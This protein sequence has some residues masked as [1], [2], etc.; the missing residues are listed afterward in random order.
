MTTKA[1]ESGDRASG[2]NVFSTL[3]V[4]REAERAFQ[5]LISPP[6]ANSKSFLGW[7]GKSEPAEKLVNIVKNRTNGEAIVLRRFAKSSKRLRDGLAGLLLASDREVASNE[8][9]NETMNTGQ[10]LRLLINHT[11]I[12]YN[13]FSA[14][15]TSGAQ[16]GT[17]GIRFL[18]HSTRTSRVLSRD[19]AININ[20]FISGLTQS[21]NPFRS[22]R[23][24]SLEEYLIRHH[25]R[26]VEHLQGTGPRPFYRSEYKSSEDYAA[27]S[28]LTPER[29]SLI[30][31]KLAVFATAEPS[32]PLKS[33]Y[34]EEER[35]M[36]LQI[37]VILVT[38]EG[39]SSESKTTAAIL[40]FERC[41]ALAALAWILQ[42]EN[43][44]HAIAAYVDKLFVVCWDVMLGRTTWQF[45]IEEHRVSKHN[46]RLTSLLN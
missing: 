29:L 28:A 35:R 17:V 39:A 5:R 2:W 25:R 12:F 20:N 23:A 44:I 6:K 40:R 26:L 32:C 1:M 24:H 38:N 19:D 27:S 14:F 41:L 22:S 4:T 43:A 34:G 30:Q 11:N 7:Q 18:L 13:A 21:D 31:L 36:W 37:L 42:M 3:T 46:T 33:L 10:L 45:D 15:L 9:L 16:G 8:V